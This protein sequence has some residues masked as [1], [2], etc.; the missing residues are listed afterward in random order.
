MSLSKQYRLKAKFVVSAF[1]WQPELTL[2]DVPFWFVEAIRLPNG[3]K[4]R[5]EKRDDRLHV[6]T[7]DG[8]RACLSGDYL[9][10]Q[11]D[12]GDIIVLSAENFEEMYELDK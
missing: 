10:R 4:N 9:L 2:D 11:A 7:F 12:S 3:A 1:Q 8:M 5:I 6:F